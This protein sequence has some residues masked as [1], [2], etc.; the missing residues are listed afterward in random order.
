MTFK[1]WKFPTEHSY[2]TLKISFRANAEKPRLISRSL[3]FGQL[4]L[5]TE[6][7][8]RKIKIPI[9]RFRNTLV[10]T[11]IT[12]SLATLLTRRFSPYF[13]ISNPPG[14]IFYSWYLFADNYELITIDSRRPVRPGA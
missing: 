7:M 10:H 11:K 4:D 3:K 9:F 2:L 13:L 1:L 6:E 8:I 14:Y 5:W 12:L